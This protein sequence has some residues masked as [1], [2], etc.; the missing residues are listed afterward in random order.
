MRNYANALV[1]LLRLRQACCHPHL[2]LDSDLSPSAEIKP[3]MDELAKTLSP[4][5]IAMIRDAGGN[6]VCPICLD[7]EPNPAIFIPCGHDP[8]SECFSHLVDPSQAIAA[9]SDTNFEA[10]CP[11][12]RGNINA[13]KIIDYNSFKRVHQ[14]ELFEEE[15]RAKLVK[16]KT[17]MRPTATLREKSRRMTVR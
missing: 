8:C 11:E 14:Q 4:Q 13:E 3:E 17:K 6:F 12:C 5:V 9:G 16:Q 2:I 15:K 7:M 1:L 10:K